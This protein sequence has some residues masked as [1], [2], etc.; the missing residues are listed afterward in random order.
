MTHATHRTLLFAC[1]AIVVALAGCIR[2]VELRPRGLVPMSAA[3]SPVTQNADGS[4]TIPAPQLAGRSQTLPYDGLLWRFARLPCVRTSDTKRLVML[5]TGMDWYA[6]VTLDVVAAERRP[7]LKEDEIAYVDR[8]R[9]G[10]AEARS[11]PAVT[12]SQTYE[13]RVGFIPIYRMR[14]WILGNM[15]LSQAKYLAFDNRS[16]RATIGQEPFAPRPGLK[17]S[18]YPM[19]MRDDR[20]V[21]EVPLAGQ[22]VPLLVD[23]AGG[24]KVILDPA[25][26]KRIRPHVRVKRAR[27]ERYPTWDGFELVDEYTL[28]RLQIGPVTRRNVV[29]WVH[30]KPKE[31]Q[32]PLLGLG[33]LDDCVVVF[34]YAGETF[35]IG[36]K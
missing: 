36:R 10:A 21:V 33:P 9:L 26:W 27:R 16:R 32:L 11:L 5:D 13:A 28:E 1:A 15:L 24:P 29:V 17:W 12:W 4:L 22:H 31:D 20:P 3:N 19:R 35:W 14:G 7:F 18:S 34:D 25:Q 30:R 23:S 2:R 8:L 6:R